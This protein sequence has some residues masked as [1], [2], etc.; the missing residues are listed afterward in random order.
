MKY[1][2]LA[3][4]LTSCGIKNLPPETD[5]DLIQYAAYFEEEATMRGRPLRATNM[6][7]KKDL[8]RKSY[9]KKEGRY[10]MAQC[11]R[12]HYYG[13]IIEIDPDV[14]NRLNEERRKMLILHEQGHCVLDLDHEPEG[15]MTEIIGEEYDKQ[16]VDNLFKI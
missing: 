9:K 5:K 2:G 4:V 1:L 16:D 8:A 12:G 6:V 11:V 14:F 10:T 7:F 15:I 3:L 13:G